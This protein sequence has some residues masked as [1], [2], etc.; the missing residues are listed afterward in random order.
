MFQR[1]I[2]RYRIRRAI[3]IG[4][5]IAGMVTARSLSPNFDE[6][7]VF[8]RDL[9]LNAGKADHPRRG[10]PQGNHPHL[11]MVAGQRVLELQFPGFFESLRDEGI[12]ALDWA[13]DIAWYQLDAWKVRFKS[14]YDCFALSRP[15][16]ERRIRE[17]TLLETRNLRLEQGVVVTNFR[18]SPDRRSVVGVSIRRGK[19]HQEALDAEL[20]VDTSGAGSRTRQWLEADG[21]GAVEKESTG[22]G[23]T[24]TSAVFEPRYRVEGTPDERGWKGIIVSPQP[25]Q[26]CGGMLFPRADGCWHVALHGYGGRAAPTDLEGFLDFAAQLSNPK[27]VRALRGARL[28]SKPVAFKIP[29]QR[30]FRFD[31]FDL[32]RGLVVLGD[33][34]NRVDPAFAQGMSLALQQVGSLATLVARARRWGRQPGSVSRGFQ[35]K[36]FQLSEHAWRLTLGKKAMVGRTRKIQLIYRQWLLD[37]TS[38]V[39]SVHGRYLAVMNLQSSLAS[40]WRPAVVAGVLVHQLKLRSRQRRALAQRASHAPVRVYVANG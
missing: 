39:P 21:F 24:Y 32:P 19:N 4:G 37:A 11:L 3:V 8:D 35:R 26:P 15:D 9:E 22:L 20:V 17:R 16:L 36:A 12:D 40:L 30:R 2:P 23:L 28:V 5:G 33:A 34:L 38:E 6:V 10:A 25:G 18:Y 27:L 7:V 29:E 1:Q 14:R 31:R 13:R